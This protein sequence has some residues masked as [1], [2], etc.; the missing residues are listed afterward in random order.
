MTGFRSPVRPLP[1]ATTRKAQG[2]DTVTYAGR[3]DAP[4]ARTGPP[5]PQSM[6]AAGADDGLGGTSSSLLAQQDRWAW[7]R[8]VKSDPTLR[9]VYRFLVGLLGVTLMLLAVAVGWLPGPAGI[10]LF[11]VG[12]ATLASEFEWAHR[13]LHKLKVH[14]QEF[15]IWAGRLPLWVRW[16]AGAATLVGVGIVGWAS[17]TLMGV[18]GWFPDLVADPLLRLPRVERP[19]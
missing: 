18:P 4:R 3:M 17:L 13:L 15:E 11:L 1:P 2:V 12:L 14:F 8:K 7:R 6:A 19:R 10:P 5:V 16:L 9:T